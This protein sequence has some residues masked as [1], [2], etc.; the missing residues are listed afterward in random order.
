MEKI[1]GITT[2]SLTT[3]EVEYVNGLIERDVAKEAV[4]NGY[5]NHQCPVCDRNILDD[6]I[7]CRSCG[8]RIRDAE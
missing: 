7:F 5:G 2:I 3:E 1:N 8:Q 6:D 4:K